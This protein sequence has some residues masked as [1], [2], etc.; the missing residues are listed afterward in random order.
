MGFDLP[1]L[2]NEL[3]SL[4]GAGR[5]DPARAL[6]EAAAKD[7]AAA[8]VK[9]VAPAPAAWC[10]FNAREV[11]VVAAARHETPPGKEAAWEAVPCTVPLACAPATG[12]A[13]TPSQQHQQQASATS[14][15]SVLEGR[16]EELLA[17]VAALTGR[18]VVLEAKEAQLEAAAA[19]AAAAAVAVAAEAATAAEAAKTVG[20]EDDQP[21]TFEEVTVA[22]RQPSW[23]DIVFGE[24]FV[25]VVC[26]G[27]PS[28]GAPGHRCGAYGARRGA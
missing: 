26:P 5:Y 13:S 10:S 3:S 4:P 11:A 27:G 19:A 1:G 16:V 22:H 25:V 17:I 6:Q 20:A 21:F 9:A 8:A 2:P 18:V 28:G 7:E 24:V 12:Y 14:S 15:S 23:T